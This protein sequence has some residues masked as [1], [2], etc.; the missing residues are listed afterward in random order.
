MQI[1]REFVRKCEGE[2]DRIIER[3]LDKLESN[4]EELQSYFNREKELKYE[5]KKLVVTE[6]LVK[7]FE[8]FPF[9][10]NKN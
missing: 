2:I 6:F 5:D 9:S 4:Y 7:P 3:K 10:G 1:F 8:K